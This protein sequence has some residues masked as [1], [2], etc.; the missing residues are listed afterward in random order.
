MRSSSK[1]ALNAVTNI[2]VYMRKRKRKGKGKGKRKRK[3]KGKR[4]G[5]GRGRGR[6]VLRRTRTKKR[7]GKGK[8][9]GRGRLFMCEYIN[10]RAVDHDIDRCA[11]QLQVNLRSIAI[12]AVTYRSSSGRIPTTQ[13]PQHQN[14]RER[15]R[16]ASIYMHARTL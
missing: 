8:R 16:Y 6:L 3:R 5:R 2:R 10:K 15:D 12:N 11:P 1:L 13:H 9:R 4:R 14:N 7:K